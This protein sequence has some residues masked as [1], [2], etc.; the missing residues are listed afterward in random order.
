MSKSKRTPYTSEYIKQFKDSEDDLREK[1]NILCELLLL[2]KGGQ[3][4]T[5]SFYEKR[6]LYNQINMGVEFFPNDLYWV[7]LKEVLVNTELDDVRF[8]DILTTYVMD[9]EEYNILHKEKLDYEQSKTLQKVVKKIVPVTTEEKREV[10]G[11]I[12]KHC[13]DWRKVVKCQ[14][15]TNK[16][17]YSF[18]AETRQFRKEFFKRN[19]GVYGS[20]W[21]KNQEKKLLK[22]SK[23]F[24]LIGKEVFQDTSFMH[25]QIGGYKVEYNTESHA[26]ISIRHFNAG[27]GNNDKSHFHENFELRTP[28]NKLN[29][30]FEIANQVNVY[31]GLRIEDAPNK[32]VG[33]FFEYR[34]KVYTVWVRRENGEPHKRE[35][36][37]QLNTF[38][39]TERREEI[40]LY[41]QLDKVDCGFVAVEDESI[42]LAFYKGFI[43]NNRRNRVAYKLP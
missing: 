13:E 9:S 18:A 32:E 5:M 7:R 12:D 20:N 37:F 17:L 28:F 36:Y 2:L 6:W 35:D 42:D 4:N 38:Y 11:F 23:Y 43:D 14:R 33:L 22:R 26:H 29:K 30:V 16:L 15:H 10:L 34:K 41:K 31:D 25:I 39:P 19:K 40:E 1:E 27:I 8:M 24:Y 21:L 3:G